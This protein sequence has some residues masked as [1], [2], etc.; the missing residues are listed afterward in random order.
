MLPFE[1]THLY[2]CPR[3]PPLHFYQ[4]HPFLPYG[5]SLNSK[6]ASA[7]VVIFLELTKLYA[8]MFGTTGY[9]RMTTRDMGIKKPLSLE[10]QT[11]VNFK[12]N[13]MKNTILIC[14]CASNTMGVY[15]DESMKSLKMPLARG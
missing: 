2:K 14:E 7:K 9:F 1:K 3:N 12:S 13:T 8:E 4:W 6:N 15:L 5:V 10:G 11:F